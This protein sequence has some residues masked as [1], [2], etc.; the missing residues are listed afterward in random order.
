MGEIDLHPLSVE[1]GDVDE[2]PAYQACGVEGVREGVIASL[3]GICLLESLILE[4]VKEPLKC[5]KPEAVC[6][7][8]RG[9]GKPY[10]SVEPS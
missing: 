3:P 2:G 6:W 10:L 8:C 5:S 9:G 4:I 7:R 1:G